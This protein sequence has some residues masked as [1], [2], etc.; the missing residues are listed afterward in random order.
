M[1]ETY[2]KQQCLDASEKHFL[3][4]EGMQKSIQQ[5]CIDLAHALEYRECN[6]IIKQEYYARGRICGILS[7]GWTID[8]V[9][10]F[11]QAECLIYTYWHPDFPKYKYVSTFEAHR[12][13][14]YTQVV[15]MEVYARHD[16]IKATKRSNYEAWKQKHGNS[17]AQKR[18]ERQ[19]K[20]REELN[21]KLNALPKA[22]SDEPEDN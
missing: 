16:K 1:L 2:T 22:A 4:S 20:L 12:V 13:T 18:K 21:A 8:E 17:Y 11:A 10:A 19:Q 9:F 15:M 7:R 3:S 14:G 5:L 6:G